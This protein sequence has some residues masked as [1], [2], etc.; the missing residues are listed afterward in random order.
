MLLT[1]KGTKEKIDVI[2]FLK[3]CLIKVESEDLISN[4]L[5]PKQPKSKLM[6]MRYT[7]YT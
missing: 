4:G 2:S 1:K 6:T 3:D 5:I 7:W